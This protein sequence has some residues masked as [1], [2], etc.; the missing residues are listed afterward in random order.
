MTFQGTIHIR[1]PG[2]NLIERRDDAQ[3]QT[4]AVNYKVKR[5]IV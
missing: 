1:Q 5:D 4:F 3:K 2:R